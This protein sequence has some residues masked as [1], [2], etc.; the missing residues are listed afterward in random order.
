MRR[1]EGGE[2]IGTRI[3]AVMALLYGLVM[4][5]YLQHKAPPGVVA[6]SFL[7]G[8]MVAGGLIATLRM[9]V[10][11]SVLDADLY[12]S[13]PEGGDKSGAKPSKVPLR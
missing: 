13:K 11:Q 5:M 9:T 1:Q 8:I 10:S 2:V 6:A 3:I 7:C 12:A 4:E